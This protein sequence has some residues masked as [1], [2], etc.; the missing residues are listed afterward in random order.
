MLLCSGDSVI[1]CLI[2][3][4]RTTILNLL[5]REHPIKAALGIYYWH[6]YVLPECPPP[7][8]TS[9]V[10]FSRPTQ[11]H[12]ST[13]FKFLSELR[14]LIRR[15]F[16]CVCICVCHI[17]SNR[18]YW[19]CDRSIDLKFHYERSGRHCVRHEVRD[20]YYTGEGICNTLDIT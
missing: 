1:R 19:S 6:Y 9:N 4:Y 13:S 14:I 18:Y 3:L 17:H 2:V 7:S 16:I 11:P 20:A 8:H 5:N 15:S 10:Q 12:V